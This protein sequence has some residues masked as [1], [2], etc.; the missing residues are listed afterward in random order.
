ML[1]NTTE[2]P[3]ITRLRGHHP[4]YIFDEIAVSPTEIVYFVCPLLGAVDCPKY[5][6]RPF[7]MSDSVS[8]TLISMFCVL[9]L[10]PMSIPRVGKCTENLAEFN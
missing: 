9:W 7:G 6:V 4:D 10:I 5:V 1:D 8:S 3:H 2:S